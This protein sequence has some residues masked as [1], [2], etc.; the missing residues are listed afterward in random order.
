MIEEVKTDS[1][2]LPLLIKWS[3]GQKVPNY[4]LTE[5]EVAELIANYFLFAHVSRVK[6]MAEKPSQPK[7]VTTKKR[8]RQ[9]ILPFPGFEKVA[10]KPESIIE[11]KKGHATIVNSLVRIDNKDKYFNLIAEWQSVADMELYFFKLERQELDGFRKELVAGGRPPLRTGE[12]RFLYKQPSLQMGEHLLFIMD[13][14]EGGTDIVHV[15]ENKKDDEKYL[16]QLY[17]N[18]LER[19]SSGQEYSSCSLYKIDNEVW[20]HFLALY[21]RTIEKKF[22]QA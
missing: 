19:W 8:P 22:F 18:C 21:D 5:N 17:T 13:R 11:Q 10:A 12:L 20:R 7:K 14:Q 6:T 3:Q 15:K 1:V 16:K 9:L 2:S 4:G